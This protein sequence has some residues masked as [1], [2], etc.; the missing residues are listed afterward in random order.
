MVRTTSHF[1]L[2]YQTLRVHVYTLN[3]LMGNTLLS[4]TFLL[5]NGMKPDLCTFCAGLQLCI[6]RLLQE[7]LW[8]QGERREMEMAS[9]KCSMWQC[10]RSHNIIPAIPSGLCTDAASHRDI[11][12]QTDVQ[13]VARCLQ[14]DTCNWYS[15]I[16]PRLQCVYCGYHSISGSLFWHLRHHETY[17]TSRAI[18][19]KFPGQFCLGMDNNYILRGLRLPIYTPTKNDVNFRA[20]IQ[21]QERLPCRKTDSFHRVLHSIQ[22]G[23]CKYP[24][25]NG[26]SWSSC[27][28]PAPTVC[29]PALQ[30]EQDERG[31]MMCMWICMCL[32]R[33]L[34]FQVARWPDG[35]CC[36]L[37]LPS[38]QIRTNACKSWEIDQHNNISWRIF[39]G[40]MASWCNRFVSIR[41]FEY[42][43][44]TLFLKC[45]LIW[46]RKLMSPC[47]LLM[48]VN[49]TVKNKEFRASLVQRNFVPC[50]SIYPYL[51]HFAA[52]LLLHL[53][54]CDHKPLL[55]LLWIF[56]V[57]CGIFLIR[58]QDSPLPALLIV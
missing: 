32:G 13:G 38:S 16:I 35:M 30:N 47:T 28:V 43:N 33:F 6:Q 15:W 9:W 42:H 29:R 56:R 19:G 12:S 57:H 7:L 26:R 1:M 4:K 39:T 37:Q 5:K 20:A 41:S 2:N 54:Y 46:F 10:C 8:L 27:W 50:V 51:E 48:T 23:R 3:L 24:L 11:P 21:I 14:E 52:T 25:G 49:S 17:C 34:G 58:R 45:K 36:E 44:D 18:G 55:S 40:E 22:R 53:L 31:I